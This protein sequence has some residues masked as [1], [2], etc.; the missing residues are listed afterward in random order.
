M[1]LQTNILIPVLAGVNI[2]C[3]GIVGATTISQRVDSQN[4][5][6]ARRQ[7]L[8]VMAKHILSDTCWV[9]KASVPF[10][11]GD[12][13]PTEGTKEGRIPTSCVKVP[14][15]S[16]YLK[17]AY[18]QGFLKVEQVFSNTEIRNQLSIK[19]KNNGIR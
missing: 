4:Q 15:T 14:K 13:V 7:S 8:A 3:L 16:Q 2:V 5:I 17:V 12:Y 6:T 1:Q 18:Y 11:I 9:N 19:E 10:K